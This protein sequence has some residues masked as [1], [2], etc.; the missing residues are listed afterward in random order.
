MSHPITTGPG[1]GRPH[2]AGYQPPPEGAGYQPAP[3]G[4]GYH[5][6]APQG[7]AAGGNGYQ[8]APRATAYQPAADPGYVGAP[9]PG[10]RHALRKGLIGALAATALIAAGL[11]AAVGTIAATKAAGTNT[12]VMQQVP[13]SSGDDHGQDVVL[14]TKYAIVNATIPNPDTKGMDLMPA[15]AALEIALAE[16]PNA[17][18]PVRQAVQEVVDTFYSAMAGYGKVRSRGLAEMPPRY[19]AEGAGQAYSR[20][21]TACG[22]D[23][24]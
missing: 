13:P 7:A 24:E 18:E 2:D 8:P 1:T 5:P 22:L 19:T 9:T 4:W 23:Q 20:A 3:E 14:C 21:W 6:V 10:A 12:V 17:S 11:G 15:A 16:N